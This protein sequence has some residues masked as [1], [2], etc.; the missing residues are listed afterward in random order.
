MPDHV[1]YGSNRDN[2]PCV[3]CWLL[4]LVG[5][6][7]TNGGGGGL[8]SLP[9]SPTQPCPAVATAAAAAT[10]TPAATARSAA[11]A[12]ATSAAPLS[13]LGLLQPRLLPLLLLVGAEAGPGIER[14][15]TQQRPVLQFSVCY[16]YTEMY[17]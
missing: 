16:F 7:S 9:T 17:G 13:L 12:A 3:G 10:A 2:V 8:A 15:K 1:V 6:T 4:C 5:A 11:A 14:A